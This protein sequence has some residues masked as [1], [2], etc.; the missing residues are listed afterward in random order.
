M[1]IGPDDEMP[2]PNEAA[3]L[4]QMLANG[5]VAAGPVLRHGEPAQQTRLL[6]E[7]TA[8]AVKDMMN[9]NVVYSYGTW[10]FPDLPLCAKSGTAEV[11]DGTSHAWFTGFLDDPDHPYAFVVVI[12]HGGGGLSQAGPAGGNEE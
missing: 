10:N 7:T 11:G 1:E 3:K 8:A 9:Y 5:G 12:E 2:T 4:M 6:S